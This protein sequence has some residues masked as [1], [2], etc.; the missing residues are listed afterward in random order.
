M[1][2]FLLSFVLQW[3]IMSPLPAVSN[4]HV[5]ST[6]TIA[7]ILADAHFPSKLPFRL[8]LTTT[9]VADPHQ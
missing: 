1:T 6:F 7:R 8:I 4:E 3:T 9:I 2:L 5:F